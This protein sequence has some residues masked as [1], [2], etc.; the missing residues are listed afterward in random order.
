MVADFRRSREFDSQCEG[1]YSSWITRV[2]SGAGGGTSQDKRHREEVVV[3]RQ[4]AG[5][6]EVAMVK[7][8]EI[9]EGDEVIEIDPLGED[10]ED[11][12]VLMP[13]A[14]VRCVEGVGS[15]EN[16]DAC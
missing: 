13:M 15:A 8:E 11:G 5:E 4:G 1:A 14:Q 7:D 16:L 6:T 12:I 10:G 9:E 3:D 2:N